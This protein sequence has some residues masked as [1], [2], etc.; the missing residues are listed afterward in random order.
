MEY[1]SS[2]KNKDKDI[3]SCTGKWM[4]RENII[5]SEVTQMPKD[6]HDGYSQ[7]SGY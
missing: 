7:I 2:I 6:I 1:Y 4:E 5:H 3:M